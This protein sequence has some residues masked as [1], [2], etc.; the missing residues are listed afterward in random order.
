MATK[1]KVSGKKLNHDLVLRIGFAIFLLIWGFDLLLK[2]Q[3]WATDSLMGE[4]YGRLGLQPGAVT[5]LGIVQ[6][7]IAFSFLFHRWVKFTSI[8]LFVML[9]VST[10]ALLPSMLA[11]LS[12]GGTPLPAILFADHFPLLAGAWAV[13]AHNK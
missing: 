10:L 5:A 2:S 13:Y 4:Y 3:Q 9:L 1:K 7:I 6:L 12:I 11:Y 8:L